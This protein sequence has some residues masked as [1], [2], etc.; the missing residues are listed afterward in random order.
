[1]GSENASQIL[2]ILNIKPIT[3]GEIRRTSVEN[4]ITYKLRSKYM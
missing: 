1:M 3:T 2:D 4:F